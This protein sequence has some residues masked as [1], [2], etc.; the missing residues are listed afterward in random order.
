MLATAPRPARWSGLRWGLTQPSYEPRPDPDLT[1]DLVAIRS[2]ELPIGWCTG[3]LDSLTL[4][5]VTTSIFEQASRLDPPALRG[6]G[7]IHLADD[8]DSLVTY[9]GRLA[10]AADLNGTPVT[11]VVGD[12][13]HDSLGMGQ[14]A[15]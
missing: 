9:D 2:T 15:P 3:E 7:A 10:E 4:I 8:L 6:L 13:G 1:A 14:P 11:V 12:D 5:D